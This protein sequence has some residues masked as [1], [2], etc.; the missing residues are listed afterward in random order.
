MRHL[1]QVLG[2]AVGVDGIRANLDRQQGCNKYGRSYAQWQ[3]V[4]MAHWQ[5]V[6]VYTW[7]LLRLRGQL[8]CSDL[9]VSSW[10]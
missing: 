2:L 3:K 8:G 9:L 10:A 1:G 7:A 5:R 6:W 4:G